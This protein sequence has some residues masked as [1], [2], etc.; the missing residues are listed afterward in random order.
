MMGWVL[1][2]PIVNSRT[3]RRARKKLKPIERDKCLVQ[4]C[5]LGER[6]KAGERCARLHGFSSKEAMIVVLSLK[7]TWVEEPGDPPTVVI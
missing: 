5:W 4:M 6:L 3:S 7:M 2:L 1:E